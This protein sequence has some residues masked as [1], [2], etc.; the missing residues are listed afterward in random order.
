MIC[1]HNMPVWIPVFDLIELNSNFAWFCLDLSNWCMLTLS[2]L[3]HMML[4]LSGEVGTEKLQSRRW[5]VRI[6]NPHG[7]S[8]SH[9]EA[10]ARQIR[11]SKV[12]VCSARVTSL[13]L[14]LLLR[15][16]PGVGQLGK[17]TFSDFSG[18]QPKMNYGT[19]HKLLWQMFWKYRVPELEK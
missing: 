19:V 7:H 1:C 11:L 2:A 9:F 15:A 14:L 5:T 13:L 8:S 3:P 12:E 17:D 16:T 10:V 6:W 18:F 4:T